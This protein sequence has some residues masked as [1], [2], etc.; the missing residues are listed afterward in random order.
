MYNDCWSHIPCTTLYHAAD[1]GGNVTTSNHDEVYMASTIIC[2]QYQK[3]YNAS[4]NL[5]SRFIFLSRDC[6][7]GCNGKPQFHAL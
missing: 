7:L 6:L 4:H 3:P 2:R 1:N 5:I